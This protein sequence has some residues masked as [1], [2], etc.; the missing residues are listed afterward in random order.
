MGD[1]TKINFVWSWFDGEGAAAKGV[2]APR[3]FLEALI[4][5]RMNS[6]LFEDA[7][8]RETFIVSNSMGVLVDWFRAIPDSTGEFV[9]RLI[10]AKAGARGAFQVTHIDEI[11]FD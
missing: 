1:K 7:E 5:D 6:N 11:T 2:H 8:R 4:V 3:A 10:E 9:T